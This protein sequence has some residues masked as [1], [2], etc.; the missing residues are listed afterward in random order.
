[1]EYV[2][3]A[4]LALLFPME[5]TKKEC[6][7]HL[8]QPGNLFRREHL[9]PTQDSADSLEEDPHGIYGWQHRQL[10]GPRKAKLLRLSTGKTHVK[11]KTDCWLTFE[12][13][14]RLTE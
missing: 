2:V 1:M 13:F 7:S 11:A 5:H 14:L 4:C 10:R 6:M 3:S 9:L 8:S 12:E